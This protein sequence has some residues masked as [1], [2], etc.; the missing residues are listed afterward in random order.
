MLGKYSNIKEILFNNLLTIFLFILSLYFPFFIFLT[1]WNLVF[2]WQNK[3]DYFYTFLSILIP[4]V[5]IYF[6]FGNYLVFLFIILII[7]LSILIYNFFNNTKSFNKTF[8]GALLYTII[9][10]VVFIVLFKFLKNKSFFVYV[11][12]NLKNYFTINMYPYVTPEIKLNIEQTLILFKDFFYS[13]FLLSTIASLAFSFKIAE[14][15]F[16]NNSLNQ[17]IVINSK[18]FINRFWRPN[19]YF[20]YCLIIN[21]FFILSLKKFVF[22]GASPIVLLVLKNTLVLIFSVYILEG[23]LIAYYFFKY[24]KLARFVIILFTLM[25]I[26]QPYFILSLGIFGIFDVFFDFRKPKGGK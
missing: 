21:L 4:S 9:C 13:I 8:L 10:G 3:F 26:F 11:Y 12:D 6:L 23:F 18:F 15:Y 20:V 24:L 19:E 14:K 17:T 2:Y 5:F 25:L 16:L 7:G 1:V 22:I